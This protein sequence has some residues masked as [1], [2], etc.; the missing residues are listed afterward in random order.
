MFPY[1][2]PLSSLLFFLAFICHMTQ[3]L[4]YLAFIWEFTVK[5]KTQNEGFLKE[6]KNIMN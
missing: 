5:M 3:Q 6:K 4:Q 1:Q 2:P